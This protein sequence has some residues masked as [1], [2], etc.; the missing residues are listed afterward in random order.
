[1]KSENANFHHQPFSNSEKAKGILQAV[2]KNSNQKD[3]FL[4]IKSSP[5][6]SIEKFSRVK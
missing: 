5:L 3:L 4:E 2:R 6:Y 1:M